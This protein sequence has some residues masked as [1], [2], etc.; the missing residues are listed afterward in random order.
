MKSVDFLIVGGSA[1]GTTAAEVVRRTK[2]DASIAIVS[3]E[4]HE[5]YSRV[6]LPHYIRH[7][8]Q[9]EQVFLKKPQ[10]YKEKN[11]EL[12]KGVSVKSLKS[13]EHVVALSNGE[14]YKYG[15]LLIT[16][17]GDVVR[18]K[19]PGS[20]FENILYFRTIEDADRIIEVE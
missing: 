8:V 15:K 12:L 10:W 19:F 3:E 17:G 18:L 7:K 14:E 11:I 6:L 1:A 4:N 16:V 5:Q 2:P 13:Q 20:D 9:R